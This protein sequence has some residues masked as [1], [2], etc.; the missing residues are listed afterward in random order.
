MNNYIFIGSVKTYQFKAKH[1]EI[2]ADPL[3]L[4]NVSKDFSVDN[5][6]KT[7]LYKYYCDFFV[8][9]DSNDVDDILIII[10]V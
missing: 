4:G 7:S 8:D 5:V 10:N 6:K 9:H 2:S 1:S 3:C